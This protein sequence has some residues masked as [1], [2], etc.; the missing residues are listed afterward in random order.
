MIN[1]KKLIRANLSLKS[2]TQKFSLIE[3]ELI[4]RDKVT[5]SKVESSCI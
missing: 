3:S 5:F 4:A 1:L 2:N